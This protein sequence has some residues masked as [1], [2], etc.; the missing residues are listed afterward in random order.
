MIPGISERTNY[1]IVDYME[2]QEEA[3]GLTRD[4]FIKAVTHLANSILEFV[5]AEHLAQQ[6]RQVNEGLLSPM[7]IRNLFEGPFE[8]LL[9]SKT[10]GVMNFDQLTVVAE[11]SGEN[12]AWR[13]QHL[14]KGSHLRWRVIDEIAKNPMQ[15]WSE[16][17]KAP[18][19]QGWSQREA[20]F[21][22]ALERKLAAVAKTEF[23]RAKA[24]FRVRYLFATEMARA[25]A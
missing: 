5:V 14:V 6:A 17:V 7:A 23:D 18:L 25:L 12:F 3:C 8:Y 15:T 20:N 21:K 13:I 22:L 10:A 4:G 1:A 2:S 9:F 19:V 11:M 24:P 16:L